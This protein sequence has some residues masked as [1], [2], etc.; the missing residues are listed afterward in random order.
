MEKREITIV[1][2]GYVGLV[3]AVALA[4]IGHKVTCMDVDKLK[5]NVLQAGQSPIYEP[6]LEELL[7][8]NLDRRNLSFTFN[9]HEAII[10]AEVIYLAVGTPS[11]K[12][13]S[14]DLTYLLEAAKAISYAATGEVVVVTKS[15]VPVGT[16]EMVKNYIEEHALHEVNI[17]VVSNPEFLREGQA[18][19]DTFHAER[20]VIGADDDYG[21]NLLMDIYEP[22]NINIIRT[23]LRSAEMIKYAS[24]AFL[25]TKISF[26][27]EIANICEKL[28]A[29]IDDVARGMGS[30]S[31]I[32]HQFLKA[33]IGYGGSCFPKDTNALMQIAGHLSHEFELL[34]SVIHVNN[35]QQALLF[36][37]AMD[38]FGRLSGLKVA[39]L[40]LSFKPNTDDMRESPAL[41]LADRLVKEGAEV[42]AFDPIAYEK[43]RAV[44]PKESSVTSDIRQAL[45]QADLAFIVTD[46]DVIK[47][48]SLSIYE[49]F[50]K[51][52]V[53]FDGRN[54]YSLEEASRHAIEYHSI[55][56]R[57]VCNLKE[58]FSSL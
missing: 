14:V 7:Q 58:I 42:T 27:N 44:L 6:G 34:K 1:G 57:A 39:L 41:T 12:D 17:H 3:T 21:A 2:A 56:R 36:E 4:E 54:C 50:M 45:Y 29:N 25:A 47:E 23:D 13:G 49:K 51:S 38:R 43:A 48:L 15:T 10:E 8:Q 53:I 20:I 5:I 31:R 11:K 37:K 16:S 19:H 35:R 18:L 32:G 9:H 33:G 55:G 22:F 30:D 46:W 24:N 26:I 40:G 28:H 52:P